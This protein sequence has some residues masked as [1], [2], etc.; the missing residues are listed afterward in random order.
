M[1]SFTPGPWVVLNPETGSVG[2]KRPYKMT[3][4]VYGDHEDCEPDERMIANARL[5]AAAPELL[6]A[7]Q[8]FL[9]E[10]PI[11][12]VIAYARECRAKASAAI[13]KAESKS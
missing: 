11:D 4:S 6:E 7:L 1:F 3:A 8:M 9:V 5:I 2:S 12:E 10:K 13:A